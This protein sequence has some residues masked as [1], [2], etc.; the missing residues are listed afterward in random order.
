[1]LF[2]VKIDTDVSEVH[3]SINPNKLSSSGLCIPDDKVATRGGLPLLRIVG[4]VLLSS[5]NNRIKPHRPKGTVL[6]DSQ[7]NASFALKESEL[8]KLPILL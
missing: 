5:S 7:I 3:N 4:G 6:G 2:R 1:M 8:N